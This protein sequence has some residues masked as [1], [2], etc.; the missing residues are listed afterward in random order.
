VISKEIWAALTF[1]QRTEL[2][3]DMAAE[4]ARGEA[5]AY[6]WGWQDAGGDG[7]DT[8]YSI[9]FGRMFGELKRLHMAE[10]VSGLGNIER[11]FQQWREH[12]SV[13]VRIRDRG[14]WALYSP[15][16]FEAPQLVPMPWT[17]EFLP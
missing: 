8:G 2:R 14:V 5:T 7:K 11:T 10:E 1:E 13:L 16:D 17:S 4:Y 12:R 3:R 6:I 15:D 9:A